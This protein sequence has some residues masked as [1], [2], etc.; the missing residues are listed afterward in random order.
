MSIQIPDF[1]GLK[2]LVVGDVMLDR[3]W[4]GDTARISPEA[5][6]PIVRVDNREERPGGAG[7]VA[8]NLAALGVETR[9]LGLCGED[10]AAHILCALLET[11]GVAAHLLAVPDLPT[12]TK[13]RVMSRHQQLLRLD[14]ERLFPDQ[15][16]ARLAE[17]FA[18]H[19]EGVDVVVLSDYGKGTLGRVEALID[20]A[21]AARIP[22]LVDPKGT[23]FNR[24]R[25]A[26]ALT[27]NLSEFLAVAGPCP[28]PVDLIQAGNAWCRKLA[29]DRLVI[30]RSEQGISLFDAVTS[31][32]HLPAQ[33]REV[34]D[35]TGAGDTV[36]AVLAAARARG[37]EWTAAAALANV[38]A[39]WVVGKLGTVA[40][41]AVELRQAVGEANGE[42]QGVMDEPA[43][44]AAV[45]RARAA[46]ERVVMTNGCFDVLHP[47][48]IRYLRQARALGDRL[49]VAVNDDAS[50][51]RLKGVDR[52]VNALAD[53]MALL[54]ALDDVD[55]VV[56]FS[57]DTPERL[58]SAV[59]PDVLV[60]GGDY[61]VEQIAGARCVQAAGGE[62]RVLPFV[63]GY[64]T[65]GLLDRVRK[66]GDA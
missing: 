36:I 57:E 24:Y 12:I 60:K 56:P 65:T 50:V 43:L 23:D 35:V 9:L 51:R 17:S 15:A 64:S 21:R 47:G 6:V 46:G 10:D 58:I 14:F 20:A 3:Y 5:P 45:S 54:A 39:S 66:R 32:V 55:W 63:A 62:V 29:L 38:A 31:H 7:N 18:A 48:H 27:P 59:M 61:T 25:G 8:M 28:A 49:I 19:L 11:A 2:A 33:A 40:I 4:H 44:L 34:F 26:S 13:L 16:A 52:P 53:R 1:K 22:V 42:S 30:T 41:S 37:L